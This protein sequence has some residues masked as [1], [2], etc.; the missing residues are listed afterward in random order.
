MEQSI[1][2]KARSRDLSQGRHSE[3]ASCFS[4]HNCNLHHKSSNKLLFCPRP[5]ITRHWRLK[6]KTNAWLL[7]LFQPLR[8]V[9]HLFIHSTDIIK[10]LLSVKHCSKRE[11]TKFPSS[12]N[13]RCSSVVTN[14]TS[15]RRMW[16]RSLASVSGLKIWCCC[17]LPRGL[18]PILM[19]LWRRPSAI[20][21]IL[22]LAWELPYAMGAALKNKQTK[23][24]SLR[25]L[26]LTRGDSDHICR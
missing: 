1:L 11:Q 2:S 3:K 17:E 26:H 14:P 9:I 16:V 5:T 10:C 25:S 12:G 18:D 4:A 8:E 6:I 22:P 23:F 19:W 15:I 13:S 7:R 21:L 20:A 24:L